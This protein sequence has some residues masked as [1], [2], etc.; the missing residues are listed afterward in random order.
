MYISACQYGLSKLAIRLK[1]ELLFEIIR[2][3]ITHTLYKCKMSY[4]KNG[5]TLGLT[6]KKSHV[7]FCKL[8]SNY[9]SQRMNAQKAINLM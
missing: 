7:S 5:D 4:P 2:Q 3:A 1:L 9:T 6:K 8:S